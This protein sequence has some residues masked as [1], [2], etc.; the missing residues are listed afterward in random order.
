MTTSLVSSFCPRCDKEYKAPTK[1]EAD[2]LVRAH[3]I[4]NDDELHENLLD[5]W[6][7]TD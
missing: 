6:D 7:G 5:E 1:V 4:R 3:I 2:K